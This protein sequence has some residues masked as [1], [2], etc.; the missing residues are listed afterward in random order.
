MSY[1]ITITVRP[2]GG[3]PYVVTLDDLAANVRAGRRVIMA[4]KRE[5]M[6][7]LRLKAMG[8][9]GDQMQKSTDMFNRVI[10]AGADVD[11]A[12]AEAEAAHM[13]ALAEQVTDLKEMAEDMAEFAQAAPT[14]GGSGTK[15]LNASEK[16]ASATL[17]PSP[18]SAAL[19]ALMAAQ[20]NPPAV[21]FD[22]DGNAYHGTAPP[23]L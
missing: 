6:K 2:P 8:V 20:P 13:G 4:T 11:K 12:R 21:H 19:A 7:A 9:V 18:N 1:T 16:P 23:T 22:E 5:E 3:Q 14:A 17:K 10:A 15:P